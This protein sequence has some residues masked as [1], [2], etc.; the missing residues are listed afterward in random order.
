MHGHVSSISIC[1]GPQQYFAQVKTLTG[2]GWQRLQRLKL[3]SGRLETSATTQLSRLT[4]SLT[5]LD[6]SWNALDDAAMSQ[7]VLG[8]W[9]ALKS[10]N[11]NHNNLGA[12][13]IFQLTQADWPLEE[14]QLADNR[15]ICMQ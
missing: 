2:G 12:A 4:F 3:L 14:L 1:T 5:S 10:L 9:P 6:L 8:K 11:L 7:L 15:I 13:A